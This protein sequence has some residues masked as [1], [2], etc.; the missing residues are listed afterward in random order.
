[1]N[2]NIAIVVTLVE[3]ELV[4][5]TAPNNPIVRLC[6]MPSPT[7]CFYLGFLLLISSILT[8][9][10]FRLPFNMSSTPK[11]FPW[12]P[13]LYGFAE[14]FGAVEMRGGKAFREQMERRYMASAQFRRLILVLSYTWGIGLILAAILSTVL[15]MVLS[16]D[17]GFG[18]GWAVPFVWSVLLGVGTK[19]YAYECLRKEREEWHC[20]E[21]VKESVTSSV[22]SAIVS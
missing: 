12:R 20:D 11:G 1:M 14:D 10:K 22:D 8:T 3:I 17:V 16:E 18:V 13:A 9:L 19:T 7:I 6:A 21:E 5:G 4:A 2:V 15:I